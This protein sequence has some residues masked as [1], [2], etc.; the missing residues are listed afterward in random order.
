MDESV[1]PQ[2]PLASDLDWLLNRVWLGFGEAR[3]LA[4]APLGLTVR[5]HVLL[6]VLSRTDV[7]QLELGALARVDKSVL[8]TTI[9]ALE[10]KGLVTREADPNDRR[11]RRPSL[12]AAGTR[13]VAAANIAAAAAQSELLEHVPA[14][15][16]ERFIDAVRDL[17]LGPFASSVLF[18]QTAELSRGRRSTST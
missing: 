6:S 16:R 18:S 13:K 11:V 9:D 14:D 17:A 15:I 7:S 3:A 2:H 4:L 12:T 8:T 5:E 1:A 10:E